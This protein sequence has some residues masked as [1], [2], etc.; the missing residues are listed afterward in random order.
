L[1]LSIGSKEIIIQD[2]FTLIDGK[3]KKKELNS[4]KKNLF[5]KILEN[6]ELIPIVTFID[7]L[8][9]QSEEQLNLKKPL[10]ILEIFNENRKSMEQ[11]IKI[12]TQFSEIIEL[13]ISL[14]R[15]IKLRKE[16]EIL[17]KELE[18]SKKYKKSS[19][20]TAISDLM[21]KLSESLILNKKKLKY[22]E[23]DY[24]QRKNQINHFINMIDNFK[25]KIKELTKQK[26]KAFSQINKITREM[27]AEPT[28]QKLI[29]DEK[30]E[31]NASLTNTEKIKRL[32]MNAKEIQIEINQI[33]SNIKD[34]NLKFEELNP[35]YEI[36]EKDYDNLLEI[37]KTDEKKLEKLQSQ[38]KEKINDEESMS[39]Q[40][41][42][43]PDL[44]SIRP[45]QEIED[46]VKKINSELTEISLIDSLFN[47]KN[48]YDL[49]LIIKK[50]GE[51]SNDIENRQNEIVIDMNEEYIKNNIKSLQNLERI[52]NT[53]DMFINIFLKEINLILELQIIISPDNQNLYIHP[54]FIRPNEE[55]IKFDNLTTPEKIFF[56]IVFYISINLYIGT[57]NIVLSNL[58]IPNKYNKAGSIFRTIRK[59]L[60]IFESEERLFN[61]NLIFIISNLEM[62]KDIKK[63]KIIKIPENG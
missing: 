57:K 25:F 6:L 47:T 46:Q 53:I 11:N 51:I 37:I 20:I 22:L 16:K 4:F 28:D 59:I 15:Y 56:V 40:E 50:L 63:L 14:F 7:F 24:L 29:Q 12:V 31:L 43:I 60:P 1:K 35:L 41:L 23:E 52:L 26:K 48:Q 13:L 8:Y 62:K 10:K 2:R 32:Q 55:R 54:N 44:K 61:F 36:N 5:L 34:T 38:L 30:S 27:E 58:F 21:K 19:D 9:R 45:T 42:G 18:I 49:S 39:I 17:E 33:K 3:F